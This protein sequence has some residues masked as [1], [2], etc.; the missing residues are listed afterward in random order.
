M[1]FHRK[2]EVGDA[3]TALVPQI[4]ALKENSQPEGRRASRKED[5]DGGGYFF[6]GYHDFM[7]FMN[8]WRKCLVREGGRSLNLRRA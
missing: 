4:Q 3:H 6:G 2:L 1:E 5:G 8:F 7:I